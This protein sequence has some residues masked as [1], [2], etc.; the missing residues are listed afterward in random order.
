M[1]L[2]YASYTFVSTA[3]SPCAAWREIYAR[4]LWIVFARDTMNIN[5]TGGSRQSPDNAEVLPYDYAGVAFRKWT[6]LWRWRPK[7]HNL[8]VV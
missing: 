2:N 4:R 3:G 6:L 1:V 5:E 8:F 7:K